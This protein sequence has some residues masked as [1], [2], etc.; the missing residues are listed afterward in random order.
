MQVENK[1]KT[2]D[3]SLPSLQINTSGE[4]VRL[5]QKLLISAGFSTKLD[6]QFGASTN[7]A[8]IGFQKGKGLTADGQVG[9]KTWHALTDAIKAAG[10]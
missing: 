10:N 6:A 2:S 3:I 9:Q 7:T 8:V 5:L 4:A 1:A